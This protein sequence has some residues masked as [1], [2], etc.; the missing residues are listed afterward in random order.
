[1][2]AVHPAAPTPCQSPAGSLSHVTVLL[3]EAIQALAIQPAGIYV[4][5]TFGRGGHSRGILQALGEQGRLFAFDRDPQ[6]WPAAQQLSQQDARF[7]IIPQ[8]FSRLQQDLGARGIT[9][10]DGVL[11]DLG[12]SS[13]QI[14]EAQRGFSF[15]QEG[16][17]D[18]RMDDTSGESAR[19]W[20][21]H[22]AQEEIA[23]VIQ[24]YGEERFARQIARAIVQARTQA[25]IASTIQL[26]R[27]VATAVRTREPG[28][29]PATRTFQALRIHVNQE[30]QEIAQVLPQAVEL[31]K[32]GGR[33]V[34]ISFH[35][36]EDRLVKQ[37]LR[38]QALPPEIPRG[39]AVREAERPQ[40][41]LQ[42]VGRAIR[43]T[44][45]E[46][47]ANP[48]SRSAILRV[49]QRSAA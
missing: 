22:A 38:A 18:M 35:S 8:R 47:A 44:A 12:V 1:M 33:L 7:E 20:L 32:C 9:R 21:A 36:L 41:R 42:W 30:L 34:V 13:P 43:P 37:Y 19:D 2:M 16:P 40:P 45:R 48:R 17:L 28:Q 39:M 5:G 4:D 6:A 10:V 24:E 3:A 15:R 31:L 14:D 29:D 25:P 11:L 49:A 46:V 23:R 27:I 26:A